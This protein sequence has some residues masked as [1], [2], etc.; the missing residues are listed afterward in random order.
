[1]SMA[2]S[3][4]QDR[5][6]L[7]SRNFMSDYQYYKAELIV[8]ARHVYAAIESVIGTPQ[9]IDLRDALAKALLEKDGTFATIVKSK[10]HMQPGLRA[11][12]AL[13]LA[14]VLLDDNWP[15]IST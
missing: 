14:C 5:T 11:G 6:N 3:T 15:A 9:P 10:L 13:A 1:M 2:L 4:S 12:Y 7:A 8:A